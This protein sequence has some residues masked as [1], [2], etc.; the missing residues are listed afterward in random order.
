MKPATLSHILV[1]D[2]DDRLRNLLKKYLS[3]Q[4]FMVSGAADAT[5]AREW[6]VWFDF[7]AIILDVMMP[8]ET[9]IELLASFD[10]QVKRRVLMLSAMGEAEDRVRGLEEGAQDYLVKPFEPK[11]LVLRL[12]AILRRQEQPESLQ[13]QA[14]FG[15]FSFDAQ[16][17]QL[18]KGQNEVY[19]TSG[20]V[21]LLRKFAENPGRPL[22]REELA[23]CLPGVAN[24]R[25][26]DVQVTR[27]RKKIEE[28]EGKPMHIKT[29]R[30]AGYVLYLDRSGS[31]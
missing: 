16:R 20:E 30:G 10:E 25:A 31:S 19:L 18:L 15:D 4:G 29:I 17:G 3:E 12:K 1:V 9:G 8:G 21:A 13:T 14:R 2:D 26:V 6:L 5:Q 22:S 11:E 7:D 28:S 27:L 23:Q 24:E